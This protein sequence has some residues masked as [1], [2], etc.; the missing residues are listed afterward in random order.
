MVWRSSK[1]AI[2]MAYST[3]VPSPS[4]SSDPSLPWVIDDATID[5]RR[6]WA[7]DF[8]LFIAGGFPLLK[9]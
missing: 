6:E 2:S 8:D 5:L 7:I 4:I 9:R 3:G 1:R